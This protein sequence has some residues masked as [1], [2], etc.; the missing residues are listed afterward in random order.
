MASRNPESTAQV[1]GHPIHPMLIPFPVAFLVATL[2][3]DLI[4]LRTGNPGWAT[5]SLW[6]LGAALVMAALAAVAGLI[7]FLGDERI[8]DLGRLAPHDR[9]RHR[10][11][12]GAHQLVPALCRDRARRSVR[13]RGAVAPRGADPALH[14]LARL[15]DG[16]QAPRRGLRPA[17]ASRFRGAEARRARGA[18]GA[19]PLDDS[20]LATACSA[21]SSASLSPSMTRSM[22]KLARRCRMRCGDSAL[23]R[24]SSDRSAVSKACEATRR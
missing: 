10:R 22:M 19:C 17:L 20:R 2:V 4:F 8:R 9:Q 21:K 13:R 23:P 6:L 15:G 1:A 18:S 7:D 16:L 11:R 12:A 3:S 14:R 24:P 5:A